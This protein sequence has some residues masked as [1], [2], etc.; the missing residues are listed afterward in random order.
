MQI[1][2]VEI[3]NIIKERI[4]DFK[5]NKRIYSEGKVISVMDGIIRV[6]GLYNAMQGEMLLLSKNKYAIALNL[7]KDILGAVV[8]GPYDD[9]YEGM[10]V[11]CTGKVLEIPVGN[12]F[13]GR[14]VNALGVPIDGKG[15]ISNDGYLPIENSAPKVIDRETVNEPIQ[16]GYI[17]VDSM[18]PIGKGQRELIIGD[19]KTG[20]TSLA[21]DIIINQKNL[22]VKSIYVAIGQKLSTIY[23]IV[24]AL[25]N[26][27]ALNNTIVVVASASESAS[28]QYISP[29][30]GC[31]LGEY[32]RNKG[33][34]ALIIYDD[35]SKHAISYRQISLL[36]R[37][38]PGREA[39]PGDIFYLHSRLL[40][41]SSK[42][43]KEYIFKKTNGVIKNK[44]GSLTALPI[45]ETQLGDI[46]A[47]IPTNIISI[48]DGQLFLE[49]NL[50]YS[51]IRPAI[52]LG[53]SVSR[54][55]SS[56]Q[57]EIIKKL[58]S[59]IR[60]SL[61]QYQELKSFSKFSSDLDINTKN[62]LNFG[63]KIIEL[64]K[65]KQYKPYSIGEQS[66]LLF[67]ITKKIINNISF[68]ELNSF[69]KNIL[70]YAKKKHFSLLNNINRFGKYNL[71]IKK[72]LYNLINLFQKIYY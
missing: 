39:F 67:L 14:V 64:L 61:A 9:I 35:L 50:F 22:G 46:S 58:S 68:K 43:N 34:D 18:I 49:S 23:N 21:I 54:I 13:L 53:V 40:E 52:N 28:L 45:V 44:F 38:P 24:Q 1:N 17:S 41:R 32:F 25:D 4:L 65:Q 56:A 26:Y 69:R 66:I 42:V 47:F 71:K 12:N 51:G 3:S 72:K 15:S 63:K 62:Q 8:L 31:S 7:E 37:R 20:K 48:T 27:N 57:S 5:V 70:V 59:G 60:T 30:S 55:G 36:L 33:E 2:S 16:T 29:Y 10:K 11:R 6:Y 19:R